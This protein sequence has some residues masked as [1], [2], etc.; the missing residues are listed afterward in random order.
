MS[1][2]NRDSIPALVA[3]FVAVVIALVTLLVADPVG[4]P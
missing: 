1:G 4:L 2:R 3:I